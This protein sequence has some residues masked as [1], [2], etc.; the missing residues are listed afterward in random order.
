M[1]R[2]TI[3]T[4]SI[5]IFLI[6]ASVASAMEINPRDAKEMIWQASQGNLDAVREL[7]SKG[8]SI[9]AQRPKDG[10]TAL[11]WAAQKGDASLVIGLMR[12][13]ADLKIKNHEGKTALQLAAGFGKKAVVGAMLQRADN[14]Q[15]LVNIADNKGQTPL[16]WA[17]WE[18]HE[19]VVVL[20][21]G[22]GAATNAQDGNGATPLSWARSES[23]ARLLLKAGAS[24]LPID[25][26]GARPLHRL[27]KNNIDLGQILNMSLLAK[28]LVNARDH[29]GDTPLHKAAKT[30]SHM[31]IESLIA[32]GVDVNARNSHGETALGELLKRYRGAPFAQPFATRAY[33]KELS[34]RLTYNQVFNS[35]KAFGGAQDLSSSSRDMNGGS[36]LE[37][38]AGMTFYATGQK[39][40][41]VQLLK[42]L[43]A[44]E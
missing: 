1:S 40:Q 44:G 36:L 37:L 20:L 6:S 18:N 21:L 8:V 12:L 4:I 10:M 30:G 9:N 16:H 22:Y 32:A 28:D 24:L 29:L 27:A 26:F 7:L 38:V 17:A 39:A 3:N 15:E 42:S 43:L 25:G 11:H 33:D 14:V 34:F 19:G 23:I 31:A 5:C 13:G 35:L 2:S 41:L